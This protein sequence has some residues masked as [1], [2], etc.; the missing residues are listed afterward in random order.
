[1][2]NLALMRQPAIVA[3]AGLRPGKIIRLCRHDEVVLV[4]A[5]D[6]LGLPRNSRPAP[7]KTDIG[8]MSLGVELTMMLATLPSGTVPPDG[9]SISS[10]LTSLSVCRVAG[11]L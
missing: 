6:L 10:R 7:T 8:V 9:V 1:M 5:L 2:F 3:S 11:V 4:K